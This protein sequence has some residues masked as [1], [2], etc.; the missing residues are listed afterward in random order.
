MID[1]V[2]ANIGPGFFLENKIEGKRTMSNE[3]RKSIEDIR[4]LILMIWRNA[5]RAE[6]VA[7]PFDELARHLVV[8]GIFTERAIVGETI[9]ARSYSPT[10]DECDTCEVWQAAILLPDGVG[11]LVWDSD[12]YVDLPSEYEPSIAEARYRFVAFA[13]C[14]PVAKA[15]LL[16]HVSSLFAQI[17]ERMRSGR[18]WL[19]PLAP[20]DLNEPY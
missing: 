19:K 5:E 16:D 9:M 14:P 13:E 2:K 8:V 15:L 7:V 20:L 4:R 11:A 6:A 17:L 10:G 3:L 1:S 18:R 12:E